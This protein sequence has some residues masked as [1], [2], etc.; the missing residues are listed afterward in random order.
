MGIVENRQQL[1]SYRE[2]TTCAGLEAGECKFCQRMGLPIL[3]VRYAVCERTS[4]NQALPELSDGE[5]EAFTSLKL[6][7][8]MQNGQIQ[9]KEIPE[10]AREYF[11][12]IKGNQTTKYILRQ[13]RQ[14]YFYVFDQDNPDGMRW[15]GYAITSDGKFYQFPVLYPP[16]PGEKEFS[17]ND[18][19]TDALNAAYITIP[20][21]EKSGKVYFAYTEHP[22]PIEHIRRIGGDQAWRDQNMQSIDIPS[23]VSGD[24]CDHAFPINELPDRVGEYS[25]GRLGIR[26]HFWSCGSQLEDYEG[27]AEDLIHNMNQKLVMAPERFKDKAL[28]LAV[29]DEAGIINELNAYRQQPMQRLEDYLSR[30]DN[31]RK[32]FCLNAI[33]ALSDNFKHATYETQQQVLSPEVSR[34]EEQIERLEDAKIQAAES[35]DQDIA[36]A[37]AENDDDQV[38]WILE[39]KRKHLAWLDQQID[40]L[41]IGVTN[42]NREIQRSAEVKAQDIIEELNEDHYNKAALEAFKAEYEAVLDRSQAVLQCLD[43]DYALWVQ[44][45]LSDLISRY[46]TEDYMT[47]LGLSGL[48]TAC[49]KGGGLDQSSV[50]LW[51]NYAKDIKNPDSP[52]TRALFLNQEALYSAAVS[53]VSALDGH[54]FNAA[55]V[56]PWAN[57]YISCQSQLDH[58]ELEKAI[59]RYQGIFSELLLIAKS[60]IA[61]LAIQEIKNSQV[62]GTQ[63][64]LYTLFAYYQIIEM[65]DPSTN[66]DHPSPALV[67]IR[68]TLRVDELQQWLKYI[69]VMTEARASYRKTHDGEALKFP[70]GQGGNFAPPIAENS[71][72]IEVVIPVDPDD[73]SNVSSALQQAT[74]S[75]VKN[76]NEALAKNRQDVVLKLMDGATTTKAI[77]HGFVLVSTLKALISNKDKLG[78]SD[79]WWK[80][81]GDS[82]NLVKAIVDARESL[83]TVYAHYTGNNSVLNSIAPNTKWGMFSRVVGRVANIFALLDG[84]QKLSQVV[85]NAR[86]GLPYTAQ[87]VSGS[88]MIIGPIVAILVGSFVGAVVGVLIALVGLILGAIFTSL[89]PPAVI[90]WLNRSY[91]RNE[92]VGDLLPFDNLEEE[93]NSLEMVFKGITVEFVVGY[94]TVNSAGYNDTAIQYYAESRAGIGA[95]PLQEAAWDIDI[96][97]KFP[98]FE[99]GHFFV[100]LRASDR[101][102]IFNIFIKKGEGEDKYSIVDDISRG[103]FNENGVVS[104]LNGDYEIVDESSGRALKVNVCPSMYEFSKPFRLDVKFISNSLGVGENNV[105]DFF[106]V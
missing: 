83:T 66:Q 34:R 72:L 25:D 49:L 101:D 24:P 90:M 36:R 64:A 80:I 79:I 46:S 22:W 18:K 35:F 57:Q 44:T 69:S 99:N 59:N 89:V 103:E 81:T 28:I 92:G 32:M 75:E 51:L 21:A 96:K 45:H 50:S 40:N 94:T 2:E 86:L 30:G 106:E 39:R 29:K 84:F 17:C 91:F 82:I 47:G 77:A 38:Q 62:A 93:K 10:S 54:F 63:E 53:A 13:V 27:R 12:D 97:I 7:Q 55:D 48:I 88:L 31:R 104:N 85:R 74:Q 43:D 41:K 87:L 56:Q 1:Q 19:S 16:A 3:P 100:G 15:Y 11:S 71:E 5:I 23:W 95:M 52:L 6:D 26:K 58:V 68:V 98:D 105:E 65:G 14:G 42:V 9:S 102:D 37:R 20:T 33:N 78:E 60:S 61:G 8:S 73:V 67:P 70:D 4:D 76:R